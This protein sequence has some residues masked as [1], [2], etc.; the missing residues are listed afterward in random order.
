MEREFEN[1]ILKVTGD[2]ED[3]VI[4]RLWSFISGV[5][6]AERNGCYYGFPPDFGKRPK[7]INLF[8]KNDRVNRIMRG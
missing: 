2:H 4:D 6:V 7:R 5:H 3:V 1:T 8:I